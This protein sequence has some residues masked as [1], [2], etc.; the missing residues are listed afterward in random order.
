MEI[1]Q[2]SRIGSRG[3]AIVRGARVAGGSSGGSGL[4]V[5]F[6]EAGAVVW[7]V[8][9]CGGGRQVKRG[10]SKVL[11]QMVLGLIVWFVK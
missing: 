1:Q 11:L 4:C 8:C 10:M 5:G 9:G 6:D 3:S 2:A 7:V